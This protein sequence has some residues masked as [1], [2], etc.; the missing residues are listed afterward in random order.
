[1]CPI[2][3]AVGGDV[4]GEVVQVI[5]TLSLPAAVFREASLDRRRRAIGALAFVSTRRL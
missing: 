2:S 4:I 5:Y 3:Y 1:M